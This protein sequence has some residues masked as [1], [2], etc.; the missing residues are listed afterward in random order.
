MSARKPRNYARASGSTG[1][2][3][4]PGLFDYLEEEK[5]QDD[6]SRRSWEPAD[7]AEVHPSIQDFV[8]KTRLQAKNEEERSRRDSSPVE[9]LA[10][11]MREEPLLFISFGSGSSG[12]CAYLGTRTKGILIDA[13]VDPEIV[14]RNLRA[15]GLS[16]TNVAG[17]L[18]THDHSDH[19]RYVYKIVRLRKDVGI[20]CTPKT[21]TGLLRRHSIS[22]RVKDYH[23]PIYK[24]FPFSL[25]GM[26][27]TAFEVSH[28]G[29]D[30]C[31]FFIETASGHTFGVA[32]DIGSITDRVDFYMRKAHYV[33]LEANYDAE[34]LRTGPYTAFLKS[35]IAAPN[36]HLDNIDSGAFAAA[37]A[38]EGNLSHIFLCHLSAE[39][40]TPETAIAT[41]RS[42]LV[43]AGLGPVGDASGSLEASGCRIQLTALPRT[44]PSRLFV[45]RNPPSHGHS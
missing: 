34:M 25:A 13:G 32:T 2:P 7:L 1:D 26:T 28:D 45:F 12:N 24:E 42:H 33:M 44:A 31:G 37:I 30:N 11:G 23:R 36:G 15:N 14:E 22:R 16:M 9:P 19:V 6:G 35:R 5:R 20:Y 27:M 10:R 3:H 38:S 41:V 8:V 4:Q 43:G 17:V 40:N 29:T 39:N 21:L 18:L